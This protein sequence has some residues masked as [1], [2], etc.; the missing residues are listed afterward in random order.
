MMSHCKWNS[1]H[2]LPTLLQL[3]IG[4]IKSICCVSQKMIVITKM[5]KFHVTNKLKV[6]TDTFFENPRLQLNSNE[7]RGRKC[8]CEKIP[9][10]FIRNHRIV[11][12]PS[13]LLLDPLSTYRRLTIRAAL[14]VVVLTKGVLFS[15]QF[16]SH[17]EFWISSDDLSRDR[18]SHKHAVIRSWQS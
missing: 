17:S 5:K 1:W 15:G 4:A 16:S 3:V 8:F 18:V 14:R 10:S 2:G 7:G 6:R 13:S 12:A 9:A 11:V